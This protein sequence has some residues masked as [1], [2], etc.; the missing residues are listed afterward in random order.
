MYC[1]N[2]GK[3]LKI[4]D[5]RVKYCFECRCNQY[6]EV[7]KFENC[8]FCGEPIPYTGHRKRKMHQ[9]CLVDDLYDAIARG[10]KLTPAQ[11]SRAYSHDIKI[12]QLQEI[13]A[14]DKREKI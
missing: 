14:E 13:V 1:R 3:K 4:C 9:R 2:C 5:D 10:D 11:Q 8:M 12:K 7:I 6:G